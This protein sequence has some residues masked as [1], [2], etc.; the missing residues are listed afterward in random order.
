MNP[1][2]NRC[3]QQNGFLN[4]KKKRFYVFKSIKIKNKKDEFSQ[5]VYYYKSKSTTAADGETVLINSDLW[6]VSTITQKSLL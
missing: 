6:D 1:L 4:K 5:S 3:F 2:F